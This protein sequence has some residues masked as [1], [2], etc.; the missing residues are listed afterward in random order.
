[1]SSHFSKKN[2]RITKERQVER[3]MVSEKV[4]IVNP[5]GLHLFK[6]G[7]FVKQCKPVQIF[8]VVYL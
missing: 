7:K 3:K 5:S 8:H 2:E 6:R 4:T 1:M